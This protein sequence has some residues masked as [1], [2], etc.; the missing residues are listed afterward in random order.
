M[1]NFIGK[2]LLVTSLLYAPGFIRDNVDLGNTHT[3]SE[4]YNTYAK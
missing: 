3:Y 4:D 2:I 1:L